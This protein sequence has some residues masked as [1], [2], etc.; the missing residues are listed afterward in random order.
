MEKNIALIYAGYLLLM[1]IVTMIFYGADKSKAKKN[2]WRIREST[3][4]WLG[5]LGGAIGGIA[6]MKVFRHKTKHWYFWA[7]NIIGVL[8]HI[9]LMA[10][11]VMRSVALR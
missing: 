6:G 9:A 5:L 2:K 7:V 11:I 3:L 10:F 1:S 8:L 4:L